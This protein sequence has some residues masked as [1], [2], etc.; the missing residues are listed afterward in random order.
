VT[1][2]LRVTS[3]T[4]IPVAIPTGVGYAPYMPTPN[5][6]TP[7]VHVRDFR[8]GETITIR[9]GSGR[10]IGWAVGLVLGAQEVA[11]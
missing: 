9:P 7:T 8:T 10:T 5:T 1:G 6:L 4:P 11:R 3:A 2:A